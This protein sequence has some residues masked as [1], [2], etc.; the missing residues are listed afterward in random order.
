MLGVLLNAYRRSCQRNIG[1]KAASMRVREG[2][3]SAV[4]SLSA[5]NH[6]STKLLDFMHPIDAIQ[7]LYSEVT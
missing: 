3:T 7:N 5:I 2:H 1:R 4:F 6:M